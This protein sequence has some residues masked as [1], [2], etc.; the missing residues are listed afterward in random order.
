[1]P[2]YPCS[3]FLEEKQPL[4]TPF[5]PPFFYPYIMVDFLVVT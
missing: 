3:L 2:A 4:R 1:M 5:L